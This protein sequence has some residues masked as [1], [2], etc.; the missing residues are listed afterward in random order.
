M[1]LDEVVLVDLVQEFALL[2][3]EAVVLVLHV[4]LLVDIL[5]SLGGNIL[6]IDPDLRSFDNLNSKVI[7]D[8]W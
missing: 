6:M 1:S 5:T 4:G 7:S 3:P 2:V 8:S